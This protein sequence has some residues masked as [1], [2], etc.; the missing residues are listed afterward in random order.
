MAAFEDEFVETGADRVRLSDHT[1]DVGAGWDW[2]GTANFSAVSVQPLSAGAWSYN[3]TGAGDWEAG[4]HAILPAL[5]SADQQAWGKRVSTQD[6]N[7]VY[8]ALAVRMIDEDNF[9]G[10]RVV[11]G[12]AAGRRLTKVVAGSVSDLVTSQGV[13]GEWLRVTAEGSTLAFWRAADGAEPT[14]PG[15]D[16]NWTQIGVDQTGHTELQS[17]TGCGIATTVTSGT[18]LMSSFRADVYPL[19]GGGGGTILAHMMHYLS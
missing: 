7:E 18:Q 17:E 1:P 12:G 2:T 16:T 9:Y 10:V 6:L 13:S 3:G 8:A 15:E 4:Y 14:D 11:G 5:S 19:A